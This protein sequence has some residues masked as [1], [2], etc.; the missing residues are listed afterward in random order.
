MSQC[1]AWL[2]LSRRQ[3]AVEVRGAWR[4]QQAH[5]APCTRS[6]IKAQDWASSLCLL[7]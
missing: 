7:P 6:I 3:G 1:L 4:P 5:L 2:A